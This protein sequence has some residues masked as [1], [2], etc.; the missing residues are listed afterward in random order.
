VTGV[1]E[2]AEW[3]AFWILGWLAAAVWIAAG[4]LA[5]RRRMRRLLGAE[6][7]DRRIVV[8]ADVVLLAALALIAIALLG[9]RLAEREILVSGA[10]ADV[11]L[12]FDVSQ[13]MD[14]RDSP[15]S[16]MARARAGAAGLLERLSPGDRVAL[17]GFAGRGVAFTPL[18]ADRQAIAQ[19]LPALDSRLIEPGG[20]NLH[21]GL[22]AI[23]PLFEAGSERPRIVLVWSDG[24]VSAPAEADALELISRKGVRVLSV[25][26]GDDAGAP[27]PDGAAPLRDD[28]DRMVVSRRTTVALTR[29]AEASDGRVWQ[30]DRWGEVN[31]A[32][33]AR[34]VDRDV[35]REAGSVATPATRGQSFPIGLPSR[36]ATHAQAARG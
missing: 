12:L 24:E 4:G 1:F 35:S 21:A 9:P 17:A 18:T 16:R 29:L 34:E 10:G 8:G 36:T 20:S 25:A 23:W 33:L 30:A 19:M 32:A 2:H 26:I 11:V 13:S 15:P 28:H 5:R 14:A 22:E 31:L 6:R 27:V 3:T 7:A